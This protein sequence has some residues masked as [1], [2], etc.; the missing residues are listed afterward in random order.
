MP[1]KE[2][3]STQEFVD[4]DYIAEDA[5]VLKGGGLRKVLMVSGINVELK[6]EEE[7]G[8]IYYSYQNFL[9]TLDFSLQIVIHSRKLNVDGYMQYLDNLEEN[10][11]EDLLRNEIAEYKEFIKSFVAENDIMNKNFLVVVPYDS[12]VIPNKKT[13]S[14]I[15][16]SLGGSSGKPGTEAL[17]QE[18]LK[19]NLFQLNQRVDQVVSGLQ[20]IGLRTVALNREE[21]IELFFNLYNPSTVE[22]KGLNIPAQNE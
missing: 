15:F 13:L 19:K 9:N 12:V 20:A 6:S 22:R 11:S 18:D 1:K 2:S 4:I 7:Q 16:P 21:L 10:E 14:K 17:N 8:V 5:L 3:T